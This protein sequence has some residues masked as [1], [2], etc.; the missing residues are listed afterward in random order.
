MSTQANN[1]NATPKAPVL[2]EEGLQA[3]VAFLQSQALPVI[4]SQL[5]FKNPTQGPAE[6]DAAVG[7]M[8][9]AI[10]ADYASLRSTH[11]VDGENG[12]GDI[13]LLLEAME[14]QGL[15]V[16][17]EFKP[18]SNTVHLNRVTN[19]LATDESGNI[20]WKKLGLYALATLVVVGASYGGYKVYQN[21]KQKQ[22][23]LA[24]AA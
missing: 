22:L 6:F 1:A 10:I 11:P 17:V 8:V 21:R 16:K 14:K 20:N 5:K 23:A 9:D 2:T 3:L 15:H 18:T 24:A 12:K 4:K 7:A 19:T 13:E